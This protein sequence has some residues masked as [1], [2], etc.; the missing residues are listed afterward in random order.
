MRSTWTR[1]S[2]IP[3]AATAYVALAFREAIAQHE[4]RLWRDL[5]SQAWEEPYS[6]DELVFYSG[7]FGAGFFL[8]IHLSS[9]LANRRA[10]V[11][12]AAQGLVGAILF[13]Y[14]AVGALLAICSSPAD[15]EFYA[16]SEALFAGT[17]VYCSAIALLIRIVPDLPL[18]IHGHWRFGL[19]L[20]ILLLAITPE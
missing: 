1:I 19:C 3:I 13:G 4:P 8:L 14:G 7:L 10:S 6:F 5:L 16:G 12:N 17:L 11:L 15:F 18:Y 20:S 9:R 2:V